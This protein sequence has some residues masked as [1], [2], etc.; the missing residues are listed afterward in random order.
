MNTAVEIAD[1]TKL[2]TA[3][4]RQYVWREGRHL[5]TAKAESMRARRDQ[6]QEMFVS[7]MLPALKRRNAQ[8][9]VQGQGPRGGW[10]RAH[11]VI[12]QAPGDPK[13]VW[14]LY[15]P[16]KNVSAAELRTTGNPANDGAL[17]AAWGDGPV[18]AWASD[19]PALRE[20]VRNALQTL[21]EFLSEGV[22]SADATL[23]VQVVADPRPGY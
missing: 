22:I 3:N 16:T 9:R 23:P 11:W 5:L 2:F 19:R 10:G 21:P 8:C 20:I 4:H 18:L 12:W 7:V 17:L 14:A 13:P 6:L 1:Q 15:V